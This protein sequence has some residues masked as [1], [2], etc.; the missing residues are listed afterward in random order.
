MTA[1]ANVYHCAV[2]G[3][4]VDPEKDI[5]M[6]AGTK[7]LFVAHQKGCAPAVKGAVKATRNVLEARFPMLKLA[8]M[9][10]RRVMTT[11]E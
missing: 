9:A 7:P 11:E 1:P 5:V 2:C 6:T 10:A 8:R 3:A 4:P